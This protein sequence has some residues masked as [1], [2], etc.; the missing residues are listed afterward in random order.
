ML[1]T[2]ATGY[3]GSAFLE[4]ARAEYEVVTLGRHEPARQDP[5]EGAE[6][7]LPLSDSPSFFPCD[8]AADPIPAKALDGVS[9][10]VHLAGKAHALEERP[11]SEEESYRK[12]TLDGTQKLLAAA[13][14]QG[15]KRLIFASTVKVY[16]ENPPEILDETAPTGPKTPY[17]RTKLEAEEMVLHGGYVP[18]PVV[19]RFSMIYGG[20]ETGNMEKMEEAIRRHR[21]PPI[22][23]FGNLRSRV[24][25]D[26]AVEALILACRHEKAAGQVFNVTDGAPFST[27][28]LYLSLL[29]K[30]DRP[31]PRWTIPLG[32]L[33]LLARLGDGIGKL[34]GKRFVFDSDALQKLTGNAAFSS[35]KIQRELG[36]RAQRTAISGRSE[37][38]GPESVGR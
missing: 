27:R 26:E 28:E 32:A 5:E 17:G 12:I 34:R 1:I 4:R 16:P 23:E 36:F 37:G 13:K 8:L 7:T 33:K 29:A 10:V 35:E 25:I 20:R 30:L 9:I 19:L 18:E 6:A 24:H 15:V 21:F 3:L 11:G 38:G 2:G 31:P 22:P 14:A